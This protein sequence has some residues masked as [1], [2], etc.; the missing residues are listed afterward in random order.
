MRTDPCIGGAISPGHDLEGMPVA[1][2]DAGALVCRERDHGSGGPIASA[3]A[4]SLKGAGVVRTPEKPWAD[5]G[6]RNV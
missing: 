2:G 3:A 6:R 1:V 4:P 5:G